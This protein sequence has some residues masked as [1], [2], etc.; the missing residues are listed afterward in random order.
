MNKIGAI[1]REFRELIEE[2]DAVLDGPGA[3]QEEISEQVNDLLEE[4]EGRLYIL[5]DYADLSP[6]LGS[7]E[8]E[9]PL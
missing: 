7:E 5:C 9:D 1:N 6:K 3:T 8:E 2:I 4:F